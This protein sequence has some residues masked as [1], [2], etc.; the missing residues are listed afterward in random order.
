MFRQ[1]TFLYIQYVVTSVR[2]VHTILLLYNGVVVYR[3][4]ERVE[5]TGFPTS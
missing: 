1:R 3:R 4:E 5:M 2:H